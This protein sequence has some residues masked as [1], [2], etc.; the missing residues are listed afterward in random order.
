MRYFVAYAHYEQGRPFFGNAEWEGEPITTLE[1]IEKIEQ[2]IQHN[3]PEKNVF[4]KVL[5]WRPFE[6]T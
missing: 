3:M 4:V 2:E 6:E 5:F 1:Q